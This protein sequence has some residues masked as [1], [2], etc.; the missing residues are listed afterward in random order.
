MTK[1]LPKAIMRRSQFK[2]MYLKSKTKENLK[3]T[4]NRKIFILRYTKK[5]SR[6]TIRH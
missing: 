3:Y 2:T 1:T 5:K 6:G 4:R